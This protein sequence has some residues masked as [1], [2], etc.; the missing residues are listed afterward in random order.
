MS[1]Y[2]M[3]LLEKII[4]NINRVYEFDLRIVVYNNEVYIRDFEYEWYTTCYD[5]GVDDKEGVLLTLSDFA[6]EY[7]GCACLGSFLTPAERSIA[8]VNFGIV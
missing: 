2:L 6:T 3:T 8:L 7:S 4:N 1:K 5:Y